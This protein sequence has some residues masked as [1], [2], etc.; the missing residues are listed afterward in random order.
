M[1]A[2]NGFTVFASDATGIPFAK[3]KTSGFACVVVTPN[4][5]GLVGVPKEKPVEA[6][7]LASNIGLFALA[8]A[9]KFNGMSGFDAAFSAVIPNGKPD[10]SPPKITFV[11][12][13]FGVAG[14][15]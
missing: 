1:S 13:T 14:F 8:F 11:S 4:A 3:F 10:F 15:S 5:F 2:L 12:G 9:F 6:A 7:K